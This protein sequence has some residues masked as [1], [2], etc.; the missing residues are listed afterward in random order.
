MN[1][2]VRQ[3]HRW[4][5][6]L[7]TLTVI[8]NMVVMATGTPPAWTTYAPLLPLFVL[9]LTGLYLFALPFVTKRRSVEE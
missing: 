3:S 4:I 6:L 2:L 8:A 7:F 1:R 9:M 5:S